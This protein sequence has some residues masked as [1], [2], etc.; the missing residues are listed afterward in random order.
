[1]RQLLVADLGRQ[2]YAEAL[3]F[4]REVARGRIAGEI[5]DDVLLLVE[6]PPVVTLGR[7]AK[8][9]HLL[10]SP[11]YLRQL[12]QN[13]RLRAVQEGRLWLSSRAW[14]ADYVASRDPRGGAPG[15][16]SH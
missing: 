16:P 11:A 15:R 14:L 3:A 12:A 9:A 6:H 13:G 4:Q 8:D 5:E 2:P 1:M 10:A 7:S